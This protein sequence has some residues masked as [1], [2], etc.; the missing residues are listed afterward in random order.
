M[1]TTPPIYGGLLLLNASA[2]GAEE[3]SPERSSGIRGSLR[4][5]PF[6]GVTEIASR[7]VR[8]AAPFQGLCRFLFDEPG[9]PLRFIRALIPP[10]PAGALFDSRQE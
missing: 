2:G 7:Q 10:H 8:S 3:Y 5:T 6:Q 1:K 9:V 4:G